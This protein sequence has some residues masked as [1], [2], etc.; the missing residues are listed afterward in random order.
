MAAIDIKQV[1]N[2]FS[3]ANFEK[4]N[5]VL[6]ALAQDKAGTLKF[7]ENPDAFLREKLGGVFPNT[8]HCHVGIE[9]EIYPHETE[10]LSSQM[11]FI[12]RVK[13]DDSFKQEAFRKFHYVREPD[14]GGGGA[15]DPPPEHPPK[16]PCPGC[17]ECL[18][19]YMD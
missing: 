4:I 10:I 13:L 1:Q 8:L 3:Q 7:L 15:V 6:A 14:G 17:G 12:A 11:I 19:V 5:H 9:G 18:M 2:N 16:E